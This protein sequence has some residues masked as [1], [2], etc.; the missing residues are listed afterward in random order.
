MNR[1]C[2]VKLCRHRSKCEMRIRHASLRFYICA[3]MSLY[4]LYRSFAY[5]FGWFC[6]NVM[7]FFFCIGFSQIGLTKGLSIL[8]VTNHINGIT[9]DGRNLL[10]E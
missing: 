5:V 2:A 8:V 4:D 1:K 3:V 7:R 10:W 9:L 6:L